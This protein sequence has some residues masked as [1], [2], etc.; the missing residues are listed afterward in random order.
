MINF[1]NLK[2][3]YYILRHGESLANI[4][5]IIVSDP[6]NGLFGYGLTATGKKQVAD[7]LKNFP[8]LDS[9][10][11][12][13]SSDFLRTKQTALIAAEILQPKN[14][15]CFTQHLRE[16]FFGDWELASNDNYRKVWSDDLKK[17]HKNKVESVDAVLKR[18]FLCL[19]E[20]EDIFN[21]RNILLVSHGDT[22]QVLLAFFNDWA[23]N[24]HREIEHIGVAEIRKVG[25][26]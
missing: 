2:N 5:K 10:T 26:I 16:R 17:K 18:I 20:I 14:K 19:M 7:S 23:P 24:R 21:D 3:S 9:Q 8:K 1:Q 4:Q 6:Q 12:I 11:I 15:I 25:L 13:Y 22:L